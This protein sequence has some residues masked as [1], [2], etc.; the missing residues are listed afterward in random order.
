MPWQCS[1]KKLCFFAPI[2]PRIMLA[3]SAKAYLLHIFD[4]YLISISIV[5]GIL[6]LLGKNRKYQLD[7]RV[8]PSMRQDEALVPSRFKED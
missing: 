4:S 8:A 7:R 5:T 2:M 6:S 1:F 3:Q